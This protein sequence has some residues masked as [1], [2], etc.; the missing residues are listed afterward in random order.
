MHGLDVMD[1]HLSQAQ[2]NAQPLLPV[3]HVVCYLTEIHPVQLQV[4][5]RAGTGREG[6]H[7]API[8]FTFIILAIRQH[9]GPEALMSYL[10]HT[11]GCHSVGL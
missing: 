8:S 5:V 1:I 3:Q 4:Q 9:R 7:I 6:L 11:S 2:V 10:N